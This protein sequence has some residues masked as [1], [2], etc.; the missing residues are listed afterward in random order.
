MSEE[1]LTSAGTEDK[2]EMGRITPSA[3]ALMS[4]FLV[5]IPYKCL[6][7]IVRKAFRM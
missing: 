3:L 2:L 1:V 6:I 7:T 5:E 4:G